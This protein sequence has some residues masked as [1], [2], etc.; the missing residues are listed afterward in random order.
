MKVNITKIADELEIQFEESESYLNKE[1]GEIYTITDEEI[2]AIE[3]GEPMEDFPD[4]QQKLI[5]IAH[6]IMNG[7]NYIEL[8]SKYQI[9]SYAIMERF[10]YSIEDSKRSEAL[11]IAIQG[12]GAFARFKEACHRFD[13]IEQWYLYKT[14]ALKEIAIEWCKKNNLEYEV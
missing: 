1:D 3:E 9:N 6:Q 4:W 13:I 5:K 7:D 8:P 12:K 11:Q 10:C 14:N 2:S